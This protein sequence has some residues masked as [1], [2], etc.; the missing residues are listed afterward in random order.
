MAAPA[1][2]LVIL[3]LLAQL[4]LLA[5]RLLARRCLSDRDSANQALIVI[6]LIGDGVTVLLF[7]LGTFGAI[8]HVAVNI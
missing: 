5:V 1:S 2:G 3:G 7:A 8:F 4:L 6:E